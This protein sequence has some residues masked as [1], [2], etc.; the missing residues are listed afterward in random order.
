VSIDGLRYVLFR[1]TKLMY[2]KCN[3]IIIEQIIST[4]GWHHTYSRSV[5][6]VSE[7]NQ[8]SLFSP[9]VGIFFSVPFSDNSLHRH[10]LSRKFPTRP[11]PTNYMNLIRLNR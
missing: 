1:T 10:W 9:F 2:W 8:W 4:G 7:P 3:A 11:Y 5:R 6:R